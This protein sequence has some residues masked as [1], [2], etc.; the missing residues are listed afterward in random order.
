MLD[1]LVIGGGSAGIAAGRR[2]AG[3]ELEF[4][5]VEAA[6]RLGGRARTEDRE[7]MPLD[8][9]CGW[10]HSADRNGWAS[11]AAATG[12]PIDRTPPAWRRQFADLGFSAEEQEAAATAFASFDRRLRESPPTSDRA[13]DALEPGNPWNPYLEALSGFINGAELG[14]L[15]V[16][17]YLAY[18][19][20]DT[21]VNWRVPGGYGALIASAAQGLPAVLETE[22]TEIDW[23]GA[24]VVVRASSGAAEARTVIVA[25]PTSVLAGERIRFVPALPDKVAAA[26]SLP[27]GVAEKAFLAL[28]RIE[29]FEPDTQLLGD[30]HDAQTGAYYLRPFGRP[31]I[32]GFFGGAGAQALEA[33]GDG[34]ALDFAIGQLVA[35]LGSDIRSRLRPLVESRWRAESTIR[36]AYSHALPGHSAARA[37]L[38]RPVDERI[39]FAGEACSKTAFSTAHG[40]YETGIAAADAAVCAIRR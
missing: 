25:V 15:S 34:A 16:A 18:G 8:L 11:L 6:N 9:G 24:H 2:L 12:Q 19:D 17:D 5:I 7:G 37:E 10:L 39:F 27:L 22:V 13:A 26:A 21:E 1:V 36:G 35:L 30:P 3:A 31:L 4:L 20:A 38:A 40:A 33:E 28:D 29:P 23:S 14:R 32:E